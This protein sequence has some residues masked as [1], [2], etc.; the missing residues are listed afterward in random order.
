MH[1]HEQHL[2]VETRRRA[3]RLAYRNG[4][5]WS[6]GNGLTSTML[7]VYLAMDLGVGVVGLGVSMILAMPNIVGLLRMSAPA[8]IGRL[9]DRKIFCMV[10]F[11]LA[12]VVLLM[13]PLTVAG[14]LL[15]SARTS[16]YGLVGVWCV[17][18]LLQYLGTVALWSWLADLVPL[19]IRGRFIGRRERW[20]VAAQAVAMII[21]GLFSWCVRNHLPDWPTWVRYT[22]PTVLGSFF[23]LAAVVPLAQMPR[24][25]LSRPSSTTK[26]STVLH[27]RLLPSYSRLTALAAPLLDRRFMGLIIFG[28]WFS[29]FNGVTQS[30][31]FVY[32]GRVLGVSL[33]AMLT[34]RTVT[35]VGQFSLSPMFGRMADRIG[36]RPVLVPCLFLVAQGPLFYFLS[37]PECR[38]WFAGAWIVWIAYAGINV[39]LP[40]LMLRLSPQ[41]ANTSYI[42]A[43]YAI[44]GVCYATSTIA[45]GYLVDSPR[46]WFF[47]YWQSATDLGHCQAIFLLGWVARMA[48]V[49]ILVLLVAAPGKSC[50]LR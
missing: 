35:R 15:A 50:R 43:Y 47:E 25:G 31:H 33:F 23:M 21:T 17:F 29:F 4:M 44:T 36:N 26:P 9:G 40:N 18:H 22:V 49:P 19:G 48:A 34:L 14:G 12:A 16:L 7:V 41:R 28:C 10:T 8:L 32:G 42:A 37:T 27:W 1:D 46:L 13:L 3:R 11:A 20:M 24:V 39:A 6:F 38:W 5:L 30:A 2:T 45:G